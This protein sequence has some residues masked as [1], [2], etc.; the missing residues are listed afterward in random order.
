MLILT[1]QAFERLVSARLLLPLHAPQKDSRLEFMHY[2][3][4]VER[5][6]LK[7]AVGTIN[8]TNLTKW[9]NKAQ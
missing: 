8:Q 4:L 3:C 1:T 5:E 6:D 7:E 9:F 2:Q